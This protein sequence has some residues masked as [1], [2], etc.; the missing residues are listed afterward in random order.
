M[1]FHN[2]RDLQVWQR[3]MDLAAEVYRLLDLLPIDERFALANQLRRAVVSVPSNIADGNGRLSDQETIR[4]FAIA[5]GSAVEVET[6]LLLAV[7]IGM[8]RETDIQTALS[9]SAEV[10]RMLYAMN[11]ILRERVDSKTNKPQSCPDQQD[12]GRDV[13]VGQMSSEE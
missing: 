8:L 6:Q 9:Y 2:Y 11:K 7:R 12:K 5:N 1:Y 3:A 4:F 13:N 10:T